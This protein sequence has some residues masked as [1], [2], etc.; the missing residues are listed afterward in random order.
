[1]LATGRYGWTMTLTYHYGV[2]TIVRTY[3]GSQDL[4]NRADSEFGT[5]WWHPEL[6]RLVI[7]TDTVNLVTGSNKMIQFIDDGDVF[8]AEA[9]SYSAYVLVKNTDDTYT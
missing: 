8:T 9:G 7:D 3:Q 2:D 1:A 4:I 5:A 6:D